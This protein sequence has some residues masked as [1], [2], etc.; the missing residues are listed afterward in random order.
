MPR[1]ELS[2]ETRARICKLRAYNLTYAQIHA[3][4]PEIPPSTIRTTIA[5]SQARGEANT[6]RPRKGRPRALTEEQRDH[7]Y[8]VLSHRDPTIKMRDL[9]AE[10]DFAVKPR[11][12]RLLLREMGFPRLLATRD[13]DGSESA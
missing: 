5:R 7:V 12:M 2:P 9:L 1:H 8:D 4:F 13:R 10:I 11:A 3:V 6:S